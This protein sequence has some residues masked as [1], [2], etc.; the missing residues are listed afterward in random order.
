MDQ[1][2]RSVYHSTTAQKDKVIMQASWLKKTL[3]NQKNCG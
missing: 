1:E 3:A 2:S